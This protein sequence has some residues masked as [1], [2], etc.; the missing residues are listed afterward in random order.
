MTMT[1]TVTMMKT[2]ASQASMPSLSVG[3]WVDR[4]GRLAAKKRPSD[5]DNE[6]SSSGWSFFAREIVTFVTQ[7]LLALCKVNNVDLTS[8]H[9]QCKAR[10]FAWLL[11]NIDVVS[12]PLPSSMPP[13]IAITIQ[14]RLKIMFAV[15]V[16]MFM[17]RCLSISLRIHDILLQLSWA[18]H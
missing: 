4:W 15:K 2:N 9:D 13:F 7:Y 6:P 16:D 18:L 5:K 11:R 3:N 10:S 1:M 14:G 8:G 12:S 17:K